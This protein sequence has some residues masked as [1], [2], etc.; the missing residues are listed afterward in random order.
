MVALRHGRSFIGI[1]LNPEY[2]E[3]ARATR[4]RAGTTRYSTSAWGGAMRK[5][6]VIEGA[7]IP[8]ALATR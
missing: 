5:E 6:A 3:M 8:E 1:E 4:S 2:V 7:W